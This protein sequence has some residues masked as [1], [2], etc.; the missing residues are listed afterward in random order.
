MIKLLDKETIDKIAAGEV[1]ERPSSVVKEL[2]ENSIDAGSGAITIEI[3]DGGSTLIRVTDNGVGIDRDE[4]RLAVLSH[5]TSKIDS[6]EDLANIGSLGFRGEAL[7]T[8]AAVSETE[9]ITKTYDALVG[10]KYVVKGGAE[11]EFSEVGVPSGTTVIVRDLFYNTPARKKFLKTA[12]TEASYISDIVQRLALSHPSV[13]FK[14]ISNGRV[15]IDTSGS[16][17]V[18]D[19]VYQLFGKD[20][21]RNLLSVDHEEGEIKITGFI[22]RPNINR[23]NRSY[24][25]YF[26]N[27]RFIKNNLVN[28]AIEEGYRTFMMQHQF[29]FTVLYIELPTEKVDVNVHPTK[30]EFKYE[31]EKELFTT[32]SRGVR[33]ALLDKNLIPETGPDSEREIRA[34]QRNEEAVRLK[35]MNSGVKPAEPFERQRNAESARPV[36]MHEPVRSAS[37][38]SES[39]KFLNALKAE[40]EKQDT[41]ELERLMK[42]EAATFEKTD[43]VI[44]EPAVQ[45]DTEISSYNA[46]GQKVVMEQ[47]TVFDEDFMT[48][49]ARKKHRVIGQVFGTYWLIE[50]EDNLFIMDQHAAHEKINYEA[51]VKN[52]KEKKILSQQLLPPM[53]VTVNYAE[54]QAVM[55]NF[56]LFIK[57]GYDIEEFGGNEFKINAVPS[58]LYDIHG[59]DMFMEFVGSLIENSGYM[60]N[61]VFIRKLASMACKAAIKGNTRISQVE[62]EGLLDK[63]LTLENPY[64]CPHGRP[65]IISVSE[66]ELEKKFKRIV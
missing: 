17:S 38:V 21:T 11:R 53:I 8:I 37:K 30:M 5:A 3:K 50:Y 42:G 23:G 32:V 64:T 27:G 54:K 19:T 36:N 25:N 62:A 26:I 47:T 52:L 65:T 9:L 15:V 43:A 34:E 10:T 1:I 44:T 28:R 7:A 22:G 41:G 33:D 39:Y 49:E 24:E 14:L 13:A 55:D 31:H 48:K 6:S 20:I 60:S 2:L 58:N 12:M 18:K 40:E 61:D 45:R 57:L 4:V 59:R 56:D 35:E 46:K 51:F 66:K 63:L 29:P 16:G